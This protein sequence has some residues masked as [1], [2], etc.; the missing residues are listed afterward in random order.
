MRRMNQYPYYSRVSSLHL[1]KETENYIYKF[2]ALQNILD[3]KNTSKN[4]TTDKSVIFEYLS[5]KT[6]IYNKDVTLNLN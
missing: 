4:I 3:I 5:D 6:V 2:H 1:P